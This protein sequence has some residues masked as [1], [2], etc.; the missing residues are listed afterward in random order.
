MDRT[1][2]I[3]EIYRTLLEMEEADWIEVKSLRKG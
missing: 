2:P 1:R 3:E